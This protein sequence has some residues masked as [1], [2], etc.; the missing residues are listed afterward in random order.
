VPFPKI[1]LS[2]AAATS[3]RSIEGHLFILPAALLDASDQLFL[4]AFVKLQVV[5][6]QLTNPLFKDPLDDVP[7]RF[8]FICFHNWVIRLFLSAILRSGIS[9][10][11][12]VPPK[13]ASENF[14]AKSQ[15]LKVQTFVKPITL[16]DHANCNRPD[17]VFLQFASF[18][19]TGP[20]RRA[21][22]HWFCGESI[23]QAIAARIRLKNC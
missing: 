15:I 7:I 14:P 8:E 3:G 21:A 19:P 13:K 17:L 18:P 10:A 12:N 22:E 5:V 16:Q 20:N 11:R 9:P 2:P 4:L 6:H 23:R 1:C